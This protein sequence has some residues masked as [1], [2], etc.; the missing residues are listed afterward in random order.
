MTNAKILKKMKKI[1]GE[2]GELFSR[3][4]LR[5]HRDLCLAYGTF[6]VPEKVFMDHDEGGVVELAERSDTD[7]LRK[8]VLQSIVTAKKALVSNGRARPFFSSTEKGGRITSGLCK[9]LVK[10]PD[11]YYNRVILTIGD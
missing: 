3:E 1:K 8:K 9:L 5:V 10:R 2:E 7:E 6:K 11:T 4:Y